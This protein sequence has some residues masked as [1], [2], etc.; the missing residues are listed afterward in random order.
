M[1]FCTQSGSMDQQAFNPVDDKAREIAQKI[2]RGR[3][4]I[5]A[6]NGSSNTSIF[7]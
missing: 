6:E 5:A 2:M 4:R 3:E 1:I 7:S